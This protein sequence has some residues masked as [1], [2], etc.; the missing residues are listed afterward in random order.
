M[1]V[2]QHGFTEEEMARRKEGIRWLLEQLKPVPISGVSLT[3][4]E[5]ASKH[6]GLVGDIDKK[7]KEAE[8]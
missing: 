3:R 6:P 2:T 1:T 4:Q 8:L 7:V 5:L